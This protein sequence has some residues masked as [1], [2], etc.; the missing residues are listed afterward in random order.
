MP[1]DSS[2]ARFSPEFFRFLRDLK[3]NNNRGWFLAN[4][5]RFDEF[6]QGASVRFVEAMAPVIQRI[7]PNLVGDPRPVGGSLMRIYRDVR[8]SKDKS[9]YRTSMGIH[10]FHRDSEGHEGGV[11]G[12]FLHLAP[13]ESFVAS[14]MWMSPTP[15]LA[16]IRNALLKD[17]SEWKRAKAPGLS[18]DE[19]ALKRVPPGFAPDHPLTEDLKRKSFVAMSS[20]KDSE[21]T[22]PGFGGRFIVECRS[23][24]PLNRF[25][26]NAVGV[27]Y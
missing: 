22:S 24:D 15:E 1:G 16:K 6:V 3:R 19:H 8:F 26:A 12:F 4:R 20:L 13:G 17:P 7:N 2:P 14:G 23:L 18:P 21:V 9:P 10:F 27:T 25:L 5:A 11:P